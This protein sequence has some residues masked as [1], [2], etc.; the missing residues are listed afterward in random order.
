MLAITIKEEVFGS[1]NT[2]DLK[3]TFANERLTLTELITAKVRAKV[4]NIN[5]NLKANE[6][7]HRFISAKERLL[8]ISSIKNKTNRLKDKIEEARVDP[9]KAVYEALAGFQQNAFF[10][11]IDGRQVTEL[12]EELV[13]TPQSQVQF[14]RLMPLVGG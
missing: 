11:L 3:V 6:P 9:E 10:V 13:L 5:A 7:D 1:G 4:E 2:N 8:N 14:I 12:E